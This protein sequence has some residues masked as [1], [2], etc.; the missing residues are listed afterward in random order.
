M[1]YGKPKS[2]YID[3]IKYIKPRVI[4]PESVRRNPIKVVSIFS[5]LLTKDEFNILPL[6]LCLNRWSTSPIFIVT[7]A[8]SP[9]PAFMEILV[10]VICTFLT[11]QKH[12]WKDEKWNITNSSRFARDSSYLLVD[13]TF[14]EKTMRSGDFLMKCFSIVGLKTMWLWQFYLSLFCGFFIC[15]HIFCGAIEK[16]LFW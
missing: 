3:W 8:V 14:S 13:N 10:S 7:S 2:N 11:V 15:W 16:T 5:H 6:I 12:H 9:R 4:K 1:Q